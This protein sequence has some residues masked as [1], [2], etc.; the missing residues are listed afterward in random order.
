MEAKLVQKALRKLRSTGI[1]ST[2]F[3]LKGHLWFFVIEKAFSIL[4]TGQLTYEHPVR[5]IGFATKVTPSYDPYENT[6]GEKNSLARYW[7]RN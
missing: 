5:P 7:S 3:S 1:V 6:Q 4:S 2:K